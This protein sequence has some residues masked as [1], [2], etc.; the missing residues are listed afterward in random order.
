MPL[1]SLGRSMT[2]C[3]RIVKQHAPHIAG[4]QHAPH[5]AG[6]QHAPHTAG[7]QHCSNI[8]GSFSTILSKQNLD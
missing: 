5:I 3:V 7:K 8:V 4:N 2:V 6:N 1:D